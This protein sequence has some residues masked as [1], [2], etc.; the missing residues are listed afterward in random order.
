MPV[1]DLAG[2]AA[3]RELLGG[4]LSDYDVREMAKTAADLYLNDKVDPN[5]TIAKFAEDRSL[6]PQFIA[7]I[8]E[9][10]N[11]TIYSEMFKKASPE[12]RTDIT[13]PLARGPDITR[14]LVPP[15]GPTLQ[16][17]EASAGLTVDEQ[18]DYQIA[19]PSILSRDFAPEPMEKEADAAIPHPRYARQYLGKL[20]HMRQEA[21]GTGLIALQ[22]LGAAEAAF[23][24]AAK[25]LMVTEPDELAEVYRDACHL[26]MGKIAAELIER[27]HSSTPTMRVKLAA[28]VP[29]SYLPEKDSA[30]V[31]NGDTKVLKLLRAV[32]QR[33]D[34]VGR[35]YGN[36]QMID[37]GREQMIERVRDLSS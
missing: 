31:V 27:V 6:N 11:V 13:F 14:T 5:E 37:H 34:D 25:H 22:D 8:A 1:L 33:R 35:S 24:K 16:V 20:A 4:K 28:M 2:K 19:P 10:A 32:H 36:L 29:E 17:K 30:R 12:E 9:A 21:E 7:R 26:G 23:V 18:I 3:F 15:D